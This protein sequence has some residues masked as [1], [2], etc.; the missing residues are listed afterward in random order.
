MPDIALSN[1]SGKLIKLETFRGK[2]IL[3]S[4]FSLNSDRCGLKLQHL[5]KLLK[6]YDVSQLQ[7]VGI[8][9][10]GSKKEIE[11]F[12]EKYQLSMLVW[13]GKNDQVQT[14]LNRDTSKTQE[15]LVILLLNRE[16]VVKDVFI[17][18]DPESLSQKVK[19]LIESKE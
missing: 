13:M 16:L 12:K 11:A 14:R 8:S 4:I 7:A 5:E 10:S 19:Q 1:L 15:E 18:F 3:L 17:D 9:T 2:F 6:N